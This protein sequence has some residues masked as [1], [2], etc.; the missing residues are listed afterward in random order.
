MMSDRLKGEG[1]KGAANYSFPQEILRKAAVTHSCWKNL[2]AFFSSFIFSKTGLRVF[3]M[4]FSELIVSEMVLEIIVVA[5]AEWFS[6][7]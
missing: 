7:I 5:V 2:H 3:P 4:Y 6:V 1:W